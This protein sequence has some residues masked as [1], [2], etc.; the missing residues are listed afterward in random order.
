MHA[1]GISFVTDIKILC[2][3]L[4]SSQG[5]FV[6]DY[7]FF[8]L[9]LS[10]S[11][12]PSL[13]F[14]RST[15]SSLM[16]L[17]S[18][19]LKQRFESSPS[20]PLPALSPVESDCQY[21]STKCCSDCQRETAA[22]LSH[23]TQCVY[24]LHEHKVSYAWEDKCGERRRS[25]CLNKTQTPQKLVVRLLTT[26]W[27]RKR[28]WR[29]QTVKITSREIRSDLTSPRS[30][31]T[32]T[33]TDLCISAA[34]PLH[35]PTVNH[36]HD[37]RRGEITG[38]QEKWS[39]HSL[40][41]QEGLSLARSRCNA[42]ISHPRFSSSVSSFA[43]I[44][45]SLFLYPVVPPSF[46]SLSLSLKLCHPLTL[47]HKVSQ[48]LCLLPLPLIGSHFS[49]LFSPA[50]TLH[51]LSLSGFSALKRQRVTPIATQ[52]QSMSLQPLYLF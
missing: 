32:R 19:S 50:P 39:K 21:R 20:H 42:A 15:S 24:S 38:S 26:R 30:T 4:T 51:Y 23:F 17:P 8:S 6:Q 27:E 44:S 11:L 2:K 28:G 13:L 43:L 18:R 22:C 45:H 49:L 10:L 9:P 14:Y 12:F 29:D 47:H 36:F 40:Q 25:G 31:H 33:H 48:T 35:S 1:F 46:L 37:S 41:R 5:L 3:N 52:T 7:L 16:L 34:A